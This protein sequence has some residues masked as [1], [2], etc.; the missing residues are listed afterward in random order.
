MNY[1]KT[2]KI[3]LYLIVTFAETDNTFR[4]NIF[5]SLFCTSYMF[6]FLS[7]RLWYVLTFLTGYQEYNEDLLEYETNDAWI[8]RTV[9]RLNEP[10]SAV[11]AWIFDGYTWNVLLT[12]VSWTKLI[13]L[14]NNSKAINIS[15]SE[16]LVSH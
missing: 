15:F 14:I 4:E 12:S 3:S 6:L 11:D 7:F 9:S 1:V 2:I 8:T 5:T 10:L 13:I 16:K